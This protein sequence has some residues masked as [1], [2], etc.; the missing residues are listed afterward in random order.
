MFGHLFRLKHYYGYKN[1]RCCIFKMEFDIYIPDFESFQAFVKDQFKI[2]I[3]AFF[4][5][6][7]V[8]CVYKKRHETLKITNH[9][10]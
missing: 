10:V 9:L 5:S 6:K 7:N 4:M 3:L 1:F 2:I 8:W